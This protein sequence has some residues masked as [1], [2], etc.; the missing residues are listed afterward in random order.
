MCA[1]DYFGINSSIL[2]LI[3]NAPIS[4]S[5][6]C[7]TQPPIPFLCT[8]PFL[9]GISYFVS[10]ILNTKKDLCFYCKTSLRYFF[11]VFQKLFFLTSVLRIFKMTG[12][13][14]GERELF[15]N[16]KNKH[17]LNWLP[18]FFN[19]YQICFL[20]QGIHCIAV[21]STTRLSQRLRALLT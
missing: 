10:H 13:M 18:Y 15:A 20:M 7:L 1:E 11:D 8:Y 5:V 4:W 6:A 17:L 3:F 9:L 12:R 21:R 14:G 2:T 19:Q 16:L